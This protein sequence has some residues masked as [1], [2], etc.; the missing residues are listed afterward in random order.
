LKDNKNLIIKPTD[1]NLGP[2]IMNLKDYIIQILQEHLLTDAYTQLSHLEA[3]SRME[4]IKQLL[5]EKITQN[6]NLLSQAEVTYFKRSLKERFRLPVFYGLPKVH[7]NPMSLRPVVS[8]TGSLLAVFSIWIDHKMKDLLHLVSSYLK[9]SSCLIQ[10]L[11][12]LHI[13]EGAKIFTADAKSMYTNIDTDTGIAAIQDFLE[14][15]NE[16]LPLNFPK[17]LFLQILEVIMKNNIFSFADSYWLQTSGTAMGTPAACTYATVTYGQFENTVILPN[18]Q[19]NLLYYRRYIDDVFGIWLPPTENQL[20]TWS[21]FKTTMNSWGNLQWDI[22]VPSR[23]T[24]FLDL[25]I[26][27]QD[28]KLEFSTFQKPLN[29]YLYLPPLS[30]HPHCC[31]KGLIKGELNRYWQQN[32]P[33]NF[34]ELVTKFIERLNA[35]GHS[36]TDLQPILLQAATTLGNNY[37]P[38]PNTKTDLNKTLFIHWTHHPNGIQRSDLRR[39][40][41]Q[42]LQPHDI[43]EE[44][45][46]AISRPKNLRDVL[47]RSTLSLPENTTIQNLIATAESQTVPLEEI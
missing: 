12:H 11:K 21:D 37:C 39:I 45:I 18:F 23:H 16:R 31:L 10:E 35:R 43:H 28:S 4:N 24:H 5:K 25:N 8:T 34:Q 42:T 40:Y 27:I 32:S 36:L 29:L 7:K 46:V 47:T 20:S 2:A 33:V 9:N 3:T 44:M 13:P 38:N 22:E 26:T 1:K 14:M 41:K 17:K 6:Q 15:N 19:T 30:A